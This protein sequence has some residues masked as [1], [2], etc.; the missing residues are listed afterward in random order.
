MKNFKD[1][2]GGTYQ[3]YYGYKA[4]A[5]D[6]TISFHTNGVSVPYNKPYLLVDFERSYTIYGVIAIRRRISG[7]GYFLNF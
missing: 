5:N 4:R 2:H 1:I 6:Y 7:K 3:N